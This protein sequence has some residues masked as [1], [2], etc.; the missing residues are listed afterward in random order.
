MANVSLIFKVVIIIIVYCIIVYA[1]KIMY[2]DMKNEGK[3]M[4]KNLMQ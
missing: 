3:R 2:N 4:P 1:L